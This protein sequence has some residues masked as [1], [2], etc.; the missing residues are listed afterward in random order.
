[1]AIAQR[2]RVMV[3]SRSNTRVFGDSGPTLEELRRQLQARLEAEPLFDQQLIEVWIHE[4]AQAA[5]GTV[6]SWEE[7]LAQ[8]RLAQIV[9]LLYSGEAGWAK[10]AGDVGICH[11]EMMEVLNTAPGKAFLIELKPLAPLPDDRAARRR[12][13]RFRHYVQ[14]QHR[15]RG[16]VAADPD[17]LLGHVQA[18]LREAVIRLVHLGVLEAR[19]GRYSSGQALDWSR[20]DF[21]TRK[22]E[23][24]QVLRRSL[25]E[26]GGGELPEGAIL[27]VAGKEVF[28]ACHAVPAAMSVAAAR[29]MVG[30]PFLRD[31]E[32]L[33]SMNDARG[34][35]HLIGCQKGVTEAQ[36]MRL[37][38]FP[39]ATIVATPFGVYVADGVQKIQLVCIAQCRDPTSTRHG[40]QRMLEWLA[41]SDEDENL[42]RRAASRRKIIQSIAGELD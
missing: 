5:D 13:Q 1:M 24:E 4:D 18:S 26:R 32:Y 19:K 6:D 23:T 35:V 11:A 41:Q 28:F 17:Q 7:S 25:T 33:E 39:D 42:A 27:Q 29:E 14:E 9:V 22:R 38:G 30:Q 34:P 21:Q 37:L 10:T 36:A 8:V 12:D 3:S 40:V 20:L 31:H 15:F 16:P 2:I